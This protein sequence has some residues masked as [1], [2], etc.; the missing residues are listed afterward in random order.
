[1]NLY[2]R[3]S[4][5]KNSGSTK[6]VML[7]LQISLLN[8]P[9]IWLDSIH[10]LL[11]K[12]PYSMYPCNYYSS[13]VIIILPPG[14]HNGCSFSIF[15]AAH[16]RVVLLFHW[17]SSTFTR[18]KWQPLQFGDAKELNTSGIIGFS[19]LFLNDTSQIEV[20][21]CESMEDPESSTKGVISEWI[22]FYLSNMWLSC[23]SSFDQQQA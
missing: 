5:Q 7:N 21:F 15:P 2:S 18:W 17:C 3:S 14:K 13:C 12:Y 11:L 20:L 16:F 4:S 9:A 19:V 6:N 10:I 22:R 1:M 8:V 23:S